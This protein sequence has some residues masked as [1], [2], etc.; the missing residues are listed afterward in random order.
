[1]LFKTPPFYSKKAVT[2]HQEAHK[3]I[4]FCIYSKLPPHLLQKKPYYILYLFT[5]PP[6]YLKKKAVTTTEPI[7]WTNFVFI[8]NAPLLLKKCGYYQRRIKVAPNWLKIGYFVAWGIGIHELGTFL[9][10]SELLWVYS[11][12]KPIFYAGKKLRNSI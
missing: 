6:S 4:K 1:M 3:I 12:F 5:T 8:Q 7:K 10:L 2:H 11:H 9:F